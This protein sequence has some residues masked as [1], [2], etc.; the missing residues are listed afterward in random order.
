[1]GKAVTLSVGREHAKAV[2]EFNGRMVARQSARE[3]RQFRKAMAR[4]LRR[5]RWLTRQRQ[6]ALAYCAA[7]LRR[8][9]SVKPADHS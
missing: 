8:V 6:A 1:M 3:R 9:F 5:Q 2:E 4:R 7:Q